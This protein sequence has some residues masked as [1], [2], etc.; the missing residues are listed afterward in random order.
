[1]RDFL[2][3]CENLFNIFTATISQHWKNFFF[4]FKLNIFFCMFGKIKYKHIISKDPNNFRE[5][6][7]II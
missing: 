5:I 1:M 3:A 7:K 6:G 2:Q 4:E